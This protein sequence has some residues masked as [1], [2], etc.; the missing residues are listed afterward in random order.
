ML[1]KLEIFTIGMYCNVEHHG[2][3]QSYHVI[4]KLENQLTMV[5]G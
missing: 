4:L 5:I 1:K 3:N 2:V